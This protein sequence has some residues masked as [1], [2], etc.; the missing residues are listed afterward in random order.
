MLVKEYIINN[1]LGA[2]IRNK[3]GGNVLFIKKKP[4]WLNKACI[5]PK[6]SVIIRTDLFL[7]VAK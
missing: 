6:A 5:D 2:M 7:L 3:R 4:L 1:I